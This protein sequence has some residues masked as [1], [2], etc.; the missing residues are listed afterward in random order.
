M[1]ISSNRRRIIP[2]SAVKL[3]TRSIKKRDKTLMPSGA[4]RTCFSRCS[5]TVSRIWARKI[6]ARIGASCAPNFIFSPFS[7]RMNWLP[8]VVLISLM[9]KL[10]LCSSRLVCVKRLSPCFNENSATEEIPSRKTSVRILARNGFCS[11]FCRASWASWSVSSSPM[12]V[13]SIFLTRLW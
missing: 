2:F 9:T 10:L 3:S 1:K 4:S 7:K 11:T 8:G 6:S 13:T 5:R 12:P